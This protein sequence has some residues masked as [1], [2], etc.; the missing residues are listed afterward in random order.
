MLRRHVGHG[1]RP[2]R[3]RRWRPGSRTARPFDLAQGRPE[4]VDGRG[5]CR[6][7]RSWL[8]LT[9]KRGRATSAGAQGRGR[10][11]TAQASTAPS[12][13]GTRDAAEWWADYSRVPSL[14]AHHCRRGRGRHPMLYTPPGPATIAVP[15]SRHE[16]QPRAGGRCG[17][18]ETRRG[19]DDDRGNSRPVS[20]P[21]E[22][23]R[24]RPAFAPLEFPGASARSRRSP[25]VRVMKPGTK[26]GPYE[27]IAP[28]G[29]GGPASAPL[30]FPG[31]TARPRRS[32][33]RSR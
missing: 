27:V 29:A 16:A 15:G 20:H 30:E 6:L 11:A 19:L 24:G 26:L 13:A 5:A 1:A 22:D 12:R 18:P 4:P 31:A 25:A 14:H 7:T 21:G 23:R 3:P 10:P 2:S 17:F 9:R 28:L 8:H 33:P 32:Q